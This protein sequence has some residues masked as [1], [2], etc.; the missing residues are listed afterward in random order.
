ME[1]SSQHGFIK[2]AS[3][4]K[5]SDISNNRIVYI[6]NFNTQ[7]SVENFP[8]ESCDT[9]CDTDTEE[10]SMPGETRVV[11]GD[12]EKYPTSFMSALKNAVAINNH[13]SVNKSDSI[14]PYHIPSSRYQNNNVTDLPP[15]K[16][17]KNLLNEVKGTD[18]SQDEQM[19]DQLVGVPRIEIIEEPETVKL[20]FWCNPYPDKLF[21][22]HKNNGGD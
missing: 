3:Q 4:N 17:L 16:Q 7:S 10:I 15:Q 11:N 9:F 2:P 20:L 14:E 19:F 18:Y 6:T 21:F 5:L 12:N 8:D 1:S 22:G 13:V